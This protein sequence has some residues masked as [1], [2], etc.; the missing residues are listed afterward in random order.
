MSKRRQ[1]DVELRLDD[2]GTIDE[3]VTNKTQHI[4]IERMSDHYVWV[5]VGATALN[6]YVNKG[7]L[8]M[9]EQGT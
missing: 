8:M 3:L 2:D 6:L 4:H 9:Q 5:R 7:K 1:P